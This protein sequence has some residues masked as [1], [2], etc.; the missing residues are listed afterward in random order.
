MLT[1]SN[2]DFVIDKSRPEGVGDMTNEI[3]P[4]H[5]LGLI[6]GKPGSG[7]TTLLKFILK[8]DKLLFKKFDYVYIISPSFQ[9]YKSLYLP[10]SNFTNELDFEWMNK[11]ISVLKNTLVYT[12]V[13]FIFDDCL[14]DLFK[15]RFSKN[16]MEFI[17]NRRH[18]LNNGMISILMTSQKYNFIPTAIRS[19]LTLLISFKL[20]NRDWKLI[21][22][23][24]IFMDANFDDVLNYVFDSDDA[25]F[26]YRIDKNIFFKKF[27]KLAI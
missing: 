11:K 5:F 25:F 12:N 13:L 4:N 21:K 14:V 17:F 18:K 8:S 26:V 2:I 1:K 22:D 9:E 15:N 6:C 24:I 16:I 23:E 3:F 27:D 20:N 10:E 19:N 7:K